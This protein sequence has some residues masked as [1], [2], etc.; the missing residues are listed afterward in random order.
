MA[1]NNRRQR[2][3]ANS[4]R[5]ELV[6]IIRKDI[7]DPRLEMAGMIT[8]S[9]VDLTE[10]MRNATVW[11]SFMGKEEKSKEVKGAL[12]ALRSAEKFVHRLLIKRIA[13][14]VHPRLSF[15]FDNMFDRAAVASNALHEAAAVE[16]ETGAYRKEHGID[17]EEAAVSGQR[18][19]HAT[20]DPEE[21]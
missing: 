9:G 11:V 21:E 3:V 16:K 15:K 13:M 19:P 10:D 4:I 8:V 2:Q 14:K 7:S 1:E 18:K 6:A 17:P 5:E 20:E 12:E